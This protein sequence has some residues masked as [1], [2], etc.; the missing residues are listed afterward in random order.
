MKYIV[1]ERYSAKQLVHAYRFFRDNPDVTWVNQDSKW[2]GAEYPASQWF[3]WFREKLQEKINRVLVFKGKGS[4][5]E[6][7]RIQGLHENATCK[8][9]G[10]KTGRVS[11]VF[12]DR[13]CAQS[14]SN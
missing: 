4:K 9:C 11:K 5:A 7:R 3:V 8:W 14:W 10:S 6:R 1:P 13:T 12:C 2:T